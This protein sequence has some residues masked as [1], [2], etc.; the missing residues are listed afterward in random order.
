MKGELW[1]IP[2]PMGYFSLTRRGWCAV[3]EEHDVQCE[4]AGYLR[5]WRMQDEREAQAR[6]AEKATADE[7]GDPPQNSGPTSEKNSCVLPRGYDSVDTP[8]Q[9]GNDSGWD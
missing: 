8:E 4:A 7:Q 6:A 9:W 1:P 5:C 2:K 3:A